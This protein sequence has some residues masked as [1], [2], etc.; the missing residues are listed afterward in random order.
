LATSRR[1]LDAGEIRRRRQALTGIVVLAVLVV[2]P[3]GIGDVYVQNIMILTLMYMALSQAWNLLGGYCGQISLGHALY[4]GIGGYVSTILFTKLGVPPTIGMIPGGLA[5]AALALL[6]GW[7]C[8]RLSGHY[9]A[10]ATIVIAEIGYLLFLNWDWVGGALGINLPFTGQSWVT[11]Q[12]RTAKLPF[13]YAFLGL[14]S[15]LWLVSFWVE[16]SK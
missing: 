13:Y 10:I 15:V 12:F 11:F 7:P 14:A 5:A 16:N 6:V 4:F 3:L 9:Y 8:F 2:L 1:D